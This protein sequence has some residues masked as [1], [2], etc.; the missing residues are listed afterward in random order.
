M[1]DPVDFRAQFPVLERKAYFN[2]GTE[3]PLPRAAAPAGR[4]R[5]D[6]EVND[7]RCG[8]SYM[9][10]LLELAAQLRTGYAAVLGCEIEDL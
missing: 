5:I 8:K 10:S 6:L 4:E 7:G 9:T 3:G 2:A 1:T